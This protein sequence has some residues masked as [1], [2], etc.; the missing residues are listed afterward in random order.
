ML[1]THSKGKY[2][3]DNSKKQKKRNIWKILRIIISGKQVKYCKNAGKGVVMKRKGFTLVELLV[4]ISIIAL[5]MSLLMPALNK[6]KEQAKRTWCLAN[7]RGFMLCVRTYTLS[8]EDYFPHRRCLGRSC[9]GAVFMS[10]IDLPVMLISE[11]LDPKSLHCP[12]DIRKPGALTAWM[13][14]FWGGELTDE[15]WLDDAPPPGVTNRPDFSYSWPAKMFSNVPDTGILDAGAY[16]AETRIVKNW[17]LSDV[18][19]P[20][21]LIAYSDF[22]YLIDDTYYW[23]HCPSGPGMKGIAGGFVDGHAKFYYTSELDIE[24]W[25]EFFEYDTW[26]RHGPDYYDV[27]YTIYGIKGYDVK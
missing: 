13:D 14:L 21:R 5:L 12:G 11:G 8:N 7:E 19:H 1:F 23:P 3:A 4:V 24:R 16:S 9:W 10:T 2:P 18:R 20:A 15:I 27:D 25:Q 26:P 22:T 17:R 6:A